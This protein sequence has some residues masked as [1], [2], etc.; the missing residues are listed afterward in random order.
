MRRASD[1][2]MPLTVRTLVKVEVLAFAELGVDRLAREHL[3][4]RRVAEHRTSLARSRVHKWLQQASA[5][6]PSGVTPNRA[7][8]LPS[9]K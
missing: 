6:I 7:A 5:V 3:T 4:L 8:A 1:W 9:S 2:R